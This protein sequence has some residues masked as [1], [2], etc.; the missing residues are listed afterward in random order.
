[1][2]RALRVRQ[3]T[4]ARRLTLMTLPWR[5]WA[6]AFALV[7]PNAIILFSSLQFMR[8]AG[9]V[10]DWRLIEVAAD[11]I[12]TGTM[13]DWG[14]PLPNGDEYVYRYSPLLPYLMTPVMAFGLEF[15]RVLHAAVLVLLP[16]PVA[17]LALVSGPF[18]FDVA[19]GNFLIFAVVFA[20]LG[21]SGH[22]WSQ[23][24]YFALALLIP[25]PLMLPVT[26]W[27]LWRRPESRM[28]AAG[29]ALLIVPATLATGEGFA[30]IG[31]MLRGG[32]MIGTAFDWGPSRFLGAW[33]MPFG[34]ALG[35]WLT[36]KGR[37]G[38]A[39]LAVSPYII[40][41]YFLMALLELLP[42]RI[43]RARME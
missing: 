24:A 33:W 12:G 34:L 7:V 9:Y 41:Y 36:W 22:R 23:A 27:L 35:A 40:P 10:F 14:A 5:W 25:R 19:N 16:L 29:V 42:Q 38:L 39:S 21:L 30:W 8:E 15:W 43:K 11:R 4:L 32:D 1:M 17:A 18:W 2:I 20:C 26:V 31:A 28:V 13:Y 3:L 37:L 6:L